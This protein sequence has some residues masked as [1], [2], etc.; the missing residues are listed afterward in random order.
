MPPHGYRH[1]HVTPRTRHPADDRNIIRIY[2]G[3]H[4]ALMRGGRALAGRM[5]ASGHHGENAPLVGDVADEM[6]AGGRTI[7]AFL[8]Q[9]GGSPPRLK[10]GAMALGERLGRFKL[11][12]RLLTR[13]PVSDLYEL[14]ALGGAVTASGAFWRAVERAGFAAEAPVRAHI[15]RCAELAALIDEARLGAASRALRPRSAMAAP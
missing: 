14:E 6:T 11:N 4:M 1:A 8:G 12:G 5:L 13:S 10:L 15:D 9:L 2:L 3:D 7:E